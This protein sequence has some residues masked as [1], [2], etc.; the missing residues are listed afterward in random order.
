MYLVVTVSQI[1]DLSSKFFAL[2]MFV[3]MTWELILAP[4]RCSCW[5]QGRIPK[6]YVQFVWRNSRLVLG[7]TVRGVMS[8]FLLLGCPGVALYATRA[9]NFY[10]QRSRDNELLCDSWLC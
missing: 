8:R 5:A 1:R 9:P 6:K 4:G 2:I 3:R 7:L 10:W